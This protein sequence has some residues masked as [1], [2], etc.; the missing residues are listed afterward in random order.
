LTRDYRLIRSGRRTLSLEIT[1]K[2][3]VLVRAPERCPQSEID[4]FVSSHEA[5]IEKHIELQRLR[6][7]AYPEPTEEERLTCVRRAEEEL[8]RKAAHYASILG[9][10]PNGIRITGAKK[11]FGSCSPKNRLCFS[12]RLM[13]Y[14][15]EAIDYVVVHELAH[16][17]HKNHGR[18]FYEL[19]SSVLPDYKSR[20]KLLKAQPAERG[21]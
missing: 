14:P 11:R 16:I 21:R 19:I 1:D 8:P 2:P 7:M 9:V 20:R 18:K 4:R 10:R 12:W 15:D 5:W 13:R 3:E 6:N 17:V